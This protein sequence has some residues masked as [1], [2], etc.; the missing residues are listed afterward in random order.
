MH[1]QIVTSTP[2][3][4]LHGLS[5]ERRRRRIRLLEK[6]RQLRRLART[7]ADLWLAEQYEAAA[8]LL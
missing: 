1:P 7:E 4:P 2:H 8:A 6:A 5:G 3:Q